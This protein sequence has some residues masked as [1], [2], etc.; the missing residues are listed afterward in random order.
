MVSCCDNGSRPPS[1]D[2]DED[3]FPESVFP[4]DV[5]PEEVF[6][7]DIFPRPYGEEDEVG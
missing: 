6:P 2:E 5:F 7:S 1:D 4:R 3:A